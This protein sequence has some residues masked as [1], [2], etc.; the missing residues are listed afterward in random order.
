[1]RDRT[2]GKGRSDSLYIFSIQTLT[3][4]VDIKIRFGSACVAIG[5]GSVR[6][7]GN[8]KLLCCKVDFSGRSTESTIQAAYCRRLPVI[9][10]CHTSTRFSLHR[11]MGRL[12]AKS[13]LNVLI[14]QRRTRTLNERGKAVQEEAEM[15]KVKSQLRR[16]K[17]FPWRL[18]KM[19]SEQ[20]F[21]LWKRH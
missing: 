18:V 6:V 13:P 1:V 11:I 2:C 10:S 8:V 14:P 4:N 17:V 16:Q 19:A 5:K 9:R 20:F 21:R 12:Q 15:K 3:P 7:R